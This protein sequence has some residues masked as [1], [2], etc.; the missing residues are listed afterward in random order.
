[1]DLYLTVPVAL[2]HTAF[3]DNSQERKAIVKSNNSFP[4]VSISKLKTSTRDRRH[5]EAGHQQQQQE[6]ELEEE[7]VK[8]DEEVREEDFPSLAEW[9]DDREVLYRERA[10]SA[11]T[12]YIRH[13]GD[14]MSALY[15]N[16]VTAK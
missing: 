16:H 8:E 6:Q 3:S 4:K 12:L 13:T 14:A 10:R 9:L 11:A 7:E 15:G 2:A 1:M 5:R